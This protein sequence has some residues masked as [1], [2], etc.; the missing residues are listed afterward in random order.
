MESL[1]GSAISKCL[2]SSLKE[3]IEKCNFVK[4]LSKCKISETTKNETDFY[5]YIYDWIELSKLSNYILTNY[6]ILIFSAIAIFLNILMI[7][8][9]SSKIIK[10]KMYFYLK[11]FSVFNLILSFISILKYVL[12]NCPTDKP[13]CSQLYKSVYSQYLTIVVIKLSGSSVRTCANIT[14]CSFTV[15]RYIKITNSENTMLKRI[16]EFPTKFYLLIIILFSFFINLYIFFQYQVEFS[17]SSFNQFQSVDSGQLINYRI[18]LIDNY[19]E[20]FSK[21]E[22]L[23]LNILQYLK[24]VFSDLSYLFVSTTIDVLLVLFLKKQNKIKQRVFHQINQNRQDEPKSRLCTILF[25]KKIKRK[26][27]LAEKAENRLTKMIILNG[28]NFILFR[29]PLALLSFY[30]YVFSYD[31]QNK[32][33]TSSIYS[34][35]VCRRHKLCESIEKIF[36]CVFLISF[37]VQFLIFYCLDKNI[38]ESVKKMKEKI[39]KNKKF[40]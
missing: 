34:Y 7:A 28:I 3:T 39:C 5:F 21:N 22:Y 15:A 18:D 38:K 6:V 33:F 29:F 26:K 20:D 17:E 30:G 27:T 11:M 13:F 12:N 19:K 10:E 37:L 36:F 8:I 14:H 4:T 16:N 23:I 1:K 32:K 35:I 25:C 9:L 40:N 24:I 31:T 2:N